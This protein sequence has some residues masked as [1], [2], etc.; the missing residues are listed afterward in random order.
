MQ[1][2]VGRVASKNERLM[3]LILKRPSEQDLLGDLFFKTAPPAPGRRSKSGAVT[4]RKKLL[5]NFTQW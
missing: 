3:R 2:D 4:P 1:R 5:D